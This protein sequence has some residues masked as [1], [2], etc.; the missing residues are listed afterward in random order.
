MLEICGMNQ[1][2]GISGLRRRF[3]IRT[4]LILC[5]GL[6]SPV[7][8]GEE[9]QLVTPGEIHSMSRE[10]A[11]LG[12]PVRVRGVVTFAYPER[13]GEFVIEDA[14]G[15]LY[16]SAGEASWNRKPPPVAS[17]VEVTGVTGEG[18]YAPVVRVRSIEILGRAELPIAR[19]VTANQ[20]LTGRF[21]S[22]R[23][24]IS[25]VVRHVTQR[26]QIES[27]A[28][29]LAG[30]FGRVTVFALESGGIM[31]S[32][33]IDAE[34]IVRGVCFPFFNER[35]QVA[36][37]RLEMNDAREVE[38]TRPPVSEP[39]STPLVSLDRLQPYSPEGAN[40]HRQRIRGTVTLVNPGDYLYLQDGDHAVRVNLAEQATAEV[41]DRVEA[42]GFPG[43]RTR[44]VEWQQAILR[45]TGSA[46]VPAPVA[47]SPDLVLFPPSKIEERAP[48]DWDGRLISLT[49]RLEKVEALKNGAR[50]LFMDCDGHVVP[51]IL[52]TPDLAGHID[53][54][55]PGSTISANGICVVDYSENW[56]SLNY[57][58]P[59][60]M[61]LLLRG[62]GDVTVLEAASW[63]TPLRLRLALGTILAI[64]LASLVWGRVL[65]RQVIRRTAALASETR[66]RRDA[67]VEFNATLRERE[68]MA[69]DLH[70]TVEQAL[71]GVSYQ[72][73]VSE[74]LHGSEP[75]R[76]VQHLDLAKQLLAQSR[77]EVRRSVWNLRAQS[78]NGRHLAEVLR[79]VAAGLSARN[80]V[81]THVTVSGDERGLPDFIAGHLL[82]LAQESMTNAIKHAKPENIRIT[83]AFD[84]SSV[85]LRVHDDGTGFDPGHA[86][87][88]AD[89]HLGLQGMRERMKRLGGVVKVESS[90]GAGTTI[91]AQVPL[92]E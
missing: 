3:L 47:I 28:L 48:N 72:L 81:Q 27:F 71:T 68:R 86:P 50:Q 78:L 32:D 44:F 22:R 40:F 89:G 59:I 88:L 61:S 55:R 49:G 75:Q 91:R 19:P 4:F 12:R 79:D 23:V 9:P 6:V 66:A 42:V 83:L 67:E 74:A 38:I 37:V 1:R 17:L 25:G 56:P 30:E 64:L 36:G 16:I 29:D 45:R 84:E 53:A 34:V 92:P 52:E 41:G 8:S 90:P 2:R 57:V 31:P 87:G 58:E 69:V 7:A 24:E 76:S 70:D 51:A 35:A 85:E 54:L 13:V 5:L 18:G 20:L 10:V 62:G 15:G 73:V 82:L 21:D 43:V 65:R 80:P 11:A 63:W 26:D 60:G 46:A 77:E 14:S 39:F 33:L